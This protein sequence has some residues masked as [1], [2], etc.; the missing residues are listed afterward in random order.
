MVESVQP[1]D[2]LNMKSHPEVVATLG[3]GKL[4]RINL[5]ET[6]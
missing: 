2:S 6:I 3:P 4:N 5:I 1:T